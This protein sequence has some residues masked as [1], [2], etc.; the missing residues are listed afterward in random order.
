MGLKMACSCTRPNYKGPGVGTWAL[1]IAL[2]FAV[3]VLMIFIGTQSTTD[4]AH[5]LTNL[6]FDQSISKVLS[7][8]N[9]WRVVNVLG[10]LH[11]VFAAACC[12]LVTLGL[13]VCGIFLCPL[14]ILGWFQTTFCVASTITTAVYLRKYL[15]TISSPQSSFIEAGDIFFAQL[16][17]GGLLAASVL[18]FA[19]SVVLS[20]ASRVSS[21]ESIPGTFMMVCSMGLFAAVGALLGAG[22]GGWSP[23]PTLTGIWVVLTVVGAILMNLRSCLLTRACNVLMIIL[24][25]VGAALALVT[26]VVM[27]YIYVT[28]LN[29]PLSRP[30]FTSLSMVMERGT[31]LVTAAAL[32]FGTFAM[33]AFATIY[34]ARSLLCCG[35]GVTKA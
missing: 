22:G 35:D 13:F 25:G 33:A 17:R 18:S 32:C 29:D 3:G 23:T 8:G 20:R 5:G 14:C 27:G 28:A 7:D 1:G 9:A 16:N 34:S 19:A 15:D 6:P 21:G 31:G 12:A 4:V 24:F 2:Q 30:D 10:W 26:A 11:L